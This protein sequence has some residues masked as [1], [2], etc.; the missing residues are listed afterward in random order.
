MNKKGFAGIGLI[1]VIVLAVAATAGG[2]YFATNRNKSSKISFSNEVI[3]KTLTLEDITGDEAPEVIYITQ[4]KDCGSCSAKTLYVYSN[5][6]EIFKTQLDYPN[7]DS[8][9]LIQGKGFS[10]QLPI[11]KEGDALCCPSSY[12]INEFIWDGE[13]FVSQIPLGWK[14]YTNSE[15]GYQISYDPSRDSLSEGEYG[16][17]INT[18]DYSGNDIF[19]FIGTAR[20]VAEGAIK[21]ISNCYDLE[22]NEVPQKDLSLNGVNFK[23]F[24]YSKPAVTSRAPFWVHY[25]A[26]RIMKDNRCFEISPHI[27]DWSK[28]EAVKEEFEILNQILDTFK[29]TK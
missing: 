2:V 15:F 3:L 21:P 10:I 5:D 14:T 20:L 24:Y 8:L 6:K 27:N 13:I 25:Y 22:P 23:S 28:G 12:S 26:Y 29:F 18:T 7:V 19:I 9:K 16:V 4:G 11:Y 1:I 17:Q